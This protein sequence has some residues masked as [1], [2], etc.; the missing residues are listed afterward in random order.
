M[1]HQ[2]QTSLVYFGEKHC[3]KCKHHSL[4]H[5][6]G[7]VEH[8]CR[9]PRNVAGVNAVDGNPILL[10]PLCATQRMFQTIS[11]EDGTVTLCGLDAR[12]FELA[13][14]LNQETL[15]KIL[16]SERGDRI[17]ASKVTEDDI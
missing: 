13:T 3:V 1:E 12:F 10:I 8:E 15:T 16:R 9:V 6:Y 5:I 14:N 11:G 17:T 7:K 4:A 2:H